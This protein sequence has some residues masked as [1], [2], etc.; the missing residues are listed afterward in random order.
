MT[1][2]LPVRMQPKTKKRKNPTDPNAPTK[3]QHKALPQTAAEEV[4]ALVRVSG[5]LGPDGSGPEPPAYSHS[6][7]RETKD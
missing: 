5:R 2:K 4:A 7:A 3:E 6:H 1:K